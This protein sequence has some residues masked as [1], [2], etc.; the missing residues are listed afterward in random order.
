MRRWIII[1][2][3]LAV[4]GGGAYYYLST[5]GM[6]PQAAMTAAATPTPEPTLP[7]QQAPSQIVAE[8]VV[9]PKFAVK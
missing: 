7:A 9:L 3:V 1:I 6:L 5:Q 4:V 8:A 2:I